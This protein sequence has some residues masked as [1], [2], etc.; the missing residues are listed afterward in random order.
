MT[1]LAIPPP[2]ARRSCVVNETIL[3]SG[4]TGIHVQGVGARVLLTQTLLI[5]GED[6]I[7]LTFETNPPRASPPGTSRP[8]AW[9]TNVQCLFDHATVAGRGSVVHV[10]DDPR[11]AAPEEPA[12]VQT[13]DCAFLN[14]FRRR[15]GVVSL[16]SQAG[17]VL[18]DGEGLS[19][20]LLV[21]QSDNDA[22]DRRLWFAAAT[23]D[24]PPPEKRQEHTTWVEWWGTPALRHAQLY[25]ATAH[26][27]DAE[28]WPLERL[29]GAKVPGA[30]LE[31]LGVTT[32]PKK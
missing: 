19:R 27:L 18:Y 2:S 4:R 32:K 16:P 5:A 20:G 11:A 29:V 25:L 12:V 13:H 3:V 31:K 1:A 6:A 22:F 17:L 7:R 8:F 21:W 28:S 15:A 30:D 24:K 9:K 26:T 23:A 10:A 14:L